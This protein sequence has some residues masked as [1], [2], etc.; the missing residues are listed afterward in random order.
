MTGDDESVLREELARLQQEH[1]DLDAAIADINLRAKA[2]GTHLHDQWTA[3]L[4]DL[5]CQA[6][7]STD[8][9][10]DGA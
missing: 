10:T 2:I 8:Q 5:Q 3:R 9:D 1:R 7:S 4:A 6:H